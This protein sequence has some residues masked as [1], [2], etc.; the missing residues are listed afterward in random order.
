MT[1]EIGNIIS[2]AEELLKETAITQYKEELLGKLP[3]ELTNTKEESNSDW[4]YG[5]GWNHCLSELKKL[6]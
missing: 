1:Y 3:K 6:L 2:Q 4:F 5:L